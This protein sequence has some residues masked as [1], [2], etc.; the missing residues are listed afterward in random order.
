MGPW[1]WRGCI[2]KWEI[3]SVAALKGHFGSPIMAVPKVRVQE[4]RR[5][6]GTTLLYLHTLTQLINL[7]SIPL[8]PPFKAINPLSALVS[9]HLKSLCLQRYLQPPA[10]HQRQGPFI[11]ALRQMAAYLPSGLAKSS[12]VLRWA[13]HLLSPSLPSPLTFHRCDLSPP[14]SLLNNKQHLPSSVKAESKS[15]LLLSLPRATRGQGFSS[16]LT[17]IQTK[18][19]IINE[20]AVLHV[21]RDKKR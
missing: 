12:K 8:P 19:L 4:G 11:R 7:L 10:S 9:S 14:L 16:C 6:G 18:R 21:R 13:G 3:V 17:E 20:R 15:T 5:P 1:R 2:S